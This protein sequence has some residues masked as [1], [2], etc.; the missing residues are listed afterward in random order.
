MRTSNC[1]PGTTN[2]E[3]R[4][5]HPFTMKINL[6]LTGKTDQEYLTEGIS[7]YTKRIKPYINFNIITT[8]AY[9]KHNSL[10]AGQRKEKEGQLIIPH[11]QKSDFCVLL[12]ERGKK[13]DSKTFATFLQERMNRS[14]KS[15]LFIVG[16]PWGFSN[17]VYEKAHFKLSLSPMTFSHQLIR[18]IFMEQ[19]YRAFTIIHNQPYH[20]D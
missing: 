6:L 19:L 17:E 20:N 4:K 12:D 14:T 1:E 15:L 3:P 16:G 8:P 7:N 5:P 11:M 2:S 10:P 9:K 18:L 13:L